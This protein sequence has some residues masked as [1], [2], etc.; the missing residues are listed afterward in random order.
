MTDVTQNTREQQPDDITKPGKLYE[1]FLQNNKLQDNANSL[2]IYQAYQDLKLIRK[3]T[4][5]KIHHSYITGI[6]PPLYDSVFPHRKEQVQHDKI[7]KIDDDGDSNDE[8]EQVIV[9]IS[10]DTMISPVELQ[11]LC[12]VHSKK[13]ATRC[14]TLAVVDEDS[15]TAYYRIF[16]QFDEIVHPQW[17]QKVKH[18]AD[19]PFH[20][21]SEPTT[22]NTKNTEKRTTENTKK[23]EAGEEDEGTHESESD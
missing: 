1:S 8:Y 13:K 22:K 9:P 10:S 19:D 2:I 16:N 7:D 21:T 20:G 14:V 17:K 18:S 4:N 5:V 15:T 3:W 6:A 11:G 23:N 12:A